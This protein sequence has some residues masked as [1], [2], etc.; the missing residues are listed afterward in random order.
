MTATEA[1][2]AWG[3]LAA[4]GG[5]FSF[6]GMAC[7]FHGYKYARRRYHGIDH[8][9][10]WIY[11]RDVGMTVALVAV[12][13]GGLSKALLLIALARWYPQYLDPVLAALFWPIFAAYAIDTLDT[14]IVTTVAPIWLMALYKARQRSG[15]GIPEGGTPT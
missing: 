2:I 5:C 14:M 12:G 1:R 6:A 15:L 3:F 8:V 11:R 7:S 4:V 10:L 13:V 9:A